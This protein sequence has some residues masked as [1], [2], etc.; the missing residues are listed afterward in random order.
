MTM[1]AAGKHIIRAIRKRK[2]VTVL[3]FLGKFLFQANRMS[4]SFVRK[5]LALSTTRMKLSYTP[6]F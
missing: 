1:G 4:P 3:S 6:A 2:A 5:V